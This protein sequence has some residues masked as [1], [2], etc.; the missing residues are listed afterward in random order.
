MFRNSARPHAI[1]TVLGL[2]GL[3]AIIFG[4]SYTSL[5]GEALPAPPGLDLVTNVLPIWVWGGLWMAA[6]AMGISAAITSLRWEFRLGFNIL[7]WLQLLWAVSYLIHWIFN[8]E[9]KSAARDYIVA[10]I[11]AFGALGLIGIIQLL[12]PMPPIPSRFR[13][14]RRR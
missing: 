1:R 5:L 8:Q 13:I 12:A 10:A 9:V 14:H 3:M 6:G 4:L 2:Y 11:F 7:V